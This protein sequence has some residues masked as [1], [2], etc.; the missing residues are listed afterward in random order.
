MTNNN[1]GVCPTCKTH[2]PLGTSRP[3]LGRSTAC[4]NCGIWTRSSE[5][6]EAQAEDLCETHALSGNC[7]AP[8]ATGTGMEALATK[9]IG[10]AQLAPAGDYHG[11]FWQLACNSFADALDDSGDHKN[12]CIIYRAVIAD[13]N[14]ETET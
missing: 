6:E 14:A 8:R 7:C 9:W 2:S 4:G 10:M 1:Y 11:M 3:G 5:W 12:A 13:M